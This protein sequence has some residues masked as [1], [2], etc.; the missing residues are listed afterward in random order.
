MNK[1][2]SQSK[3]I[4]KPTEEQMMEYFLRTDFSKINFPAIPTPEWIT[5]LGMD[6]KKMSN[7]KIIKKMYY[8][9]D[10]MIHVTLSNDVDS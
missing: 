10:G 1:V 9:S 3:Q 4:K 6:L 2:L 5:I 8:D 7:D